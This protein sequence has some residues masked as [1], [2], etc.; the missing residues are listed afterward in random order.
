MR[1]GLPVGDDLLALRDAVDLK[2]FGLEGPQ[3][4]QVL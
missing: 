3:P 4:K 1:F 2:T